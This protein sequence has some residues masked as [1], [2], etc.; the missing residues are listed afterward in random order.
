MVSVTNG[1]KGASPLTRVKRTSKS[2][3]RAWFVSSS[4]S[5]PFSRFR[6][7]RMYQFVVLSM[8]SRSR[9]TTV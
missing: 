4:P 2:V 1:A 8:R 9:G 5:S 7:K 6:L 3:L